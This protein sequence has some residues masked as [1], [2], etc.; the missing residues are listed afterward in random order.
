MPIAYHIT[1]STKIESVTMRKL[2]SHTSTKDALTCYIAEKMLQYAERHEKSV[3]VAWRNHAKGSI[4]D[5]TYLA[6]TQEEADTK[7]IWHAIDA[8]S[9]GAT[10]ISIHSQDT[11]VLVLSIR[12]FPQLCQKTSLIRGFGRSRKVIPIQPIFQA[13]G[14]IRSKALPAFHAF[15]GSDITGRFA[16]KGKATCWRALR[17]L[18]DQQLEDFAALGT[19]LK[20][21]SVTI[22]VLESFVCKL[23]LS[24]TKM[25]IPQ[26]RWWLFKKR[27]AQ[28]EN[29]PPTQSTLKSAI[30]RAHYQTMT[31]IKA[32]NADQNLPPPEQYVY[33]IEGNIYTAMT[34]PQS[35]APSAIIHLIKCGCKSSQCRTNQC[36]CR[37]NGLQ[38]T[39]LCDCSESDDCLNCVQEVNEETSSE[40][41]YDT[42]DEEE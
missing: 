32:N 33:Q 7:V 35:P 21:S 23:Y 6:S 41:D 14:P 29:L 18:N 11:D 24:R 34:T 3:I 17:E 12:H 37:R 25:S 4:R 31:W 22:C 9:Q 26:L 19:T 1:D 10:Y 20:P 15:T 13:L 27:Q 38:C 36:K 39:E 30:L 40:D 2:L 8:K 42:N 16:G 5:V 28:S